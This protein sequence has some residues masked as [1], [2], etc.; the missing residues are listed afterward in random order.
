MPFS[1]MAQ[2][3]LG[4]ALSAV[5]VANKA[6]YR[7]SEYECPICRSRLRA[8]LPLPRMFRTELEIGGRNYTARD[9]ETLAVDDYQ[10]PVCRAA[11]RDRLAALFL[12]KVLTEGAH[13]A[14]LHFA[15]ERA[16]SRFLRRLPGYDYR[17]ADLYMPGVDERVDITRIEGYEDGSVACFIC[18]HVL[19]HV[20]RD[21]EAMRELFRILRPGGWGIVMTP[22]LKG[23]ERTSEDPFVTDP[24]ER[25]RRFGQGDH[26]RVYAKADFVRRLEEA[27]FRVEQIGIASFGADVFRRAGIDP[28]SCLYVVGKGG[29][30]A[31]TGAAP[32]DAR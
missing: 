1:T 30:G 27:G 4:C 19:E 2:H 16:L 29:A 31:G 15:P 23:L 32:A 8:F 9:F 11:D 12:R 28:G 10:C 17:T 22:I 20:G 6:L 14:L 18:S 26:V 7:G 3:V 5:G 24:E 25:I 21:R 13:G